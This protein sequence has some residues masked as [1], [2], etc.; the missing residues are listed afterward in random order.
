MSRE[1]CEPLRQI[2]RTN[3]T[4]HL[5]FSLAMLG[6]GAI[7]LLASVAMMWDAQAA[8]RE[9]TPYPA[10]LTRVAEPAC[11]G[12]S[13]RM[14][15]RIEVTARITSPSATLEQPAFGGR[16]PGRHDAKNAHA[17]HRLATPT[18]V[19]QLSGLRDGYLYH[20]PMAFEQLRQDGT[21]YGNMENF[22][23]AGFFLVLGLVNLVISLVNARRLRAG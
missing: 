23:G 1:S 15:C 2:L 22:I 10:V 9:A 4:H 13:K 19:Y 6:A 20:T 21:P 17:A 14:T 7:I 8:H 11:S 12:T 3:P 5:L 18:T 16:Y